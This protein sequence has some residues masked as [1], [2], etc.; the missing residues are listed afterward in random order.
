M[1]IH[2]Q[3]NEDILDSWAVV[4]ELRPHLQK[5][6][7]LLTIR[8]MMQDDGYQ[9]I[10][11]PADEENQGV[12]AAFAGFRH[13]HSLHAGRTIY[14]D[15]LCTLPAYRGKGYG[16]QLLDYIHR[17]AGESGKDTVTLDSGHQRHAA[18]R[19]YLNK[20]YVISAHH[21]SKKPD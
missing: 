4:S 19:L 2:L 16:G 15:D 11:I 6:R 12:I 3:S 1:I 17:L 21:L 9:M 5:D 7:F 10:G 14:I 18:H 13:L 8:D 20:G